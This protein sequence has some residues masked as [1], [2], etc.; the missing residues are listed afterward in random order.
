M[1]WWS[2]RE[3]AATVGAW[4]DLN[5]THPLPVLGDRLPISN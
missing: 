1:A 4:F 3:A 2:I 5:V